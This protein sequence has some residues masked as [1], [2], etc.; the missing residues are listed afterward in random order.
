M[1]TDLVSAGFLE[2]TPDTTDKFGVGS[3][4]LYKTCNC[5]GS[6]PLTSMLLKGQLHVCV[7]VHVCVSFY[8]PHS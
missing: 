2:Q 1:S 6:V 8:Y 7:N 3:Q 4:K 5:M